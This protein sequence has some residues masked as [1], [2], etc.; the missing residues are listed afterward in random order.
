MPADLAALLKRQKFGRGTLRPFI[1][2]E[3]GELKGLAFLSSQDETSDIDEKNLSA[4]FLI[5][6]PS[7]DRALDVVPPKSLDFSN[8]EKNAT[9]LWNHG[10]NENVP[11]PLGTSIDPETKQLA[12]D[13]TERGVFAKCFFG[14]GVA[15]SEDMFKLV[16]QGIV[17]AASIHMVAPIEAKERTPAKK[18]GRP[19]YEIVKASIAEWSLVDIPC[20]QDACR[21]AADSGR[22]LNERLSDE[23]HEIL[24]GMVAGMPKPKMLGK[25]WTFDESEAKAAATND[26]KTIAAHAEIKVALDNAAEPAGAAILAGLHAQ[27]KGMLATLKAAAVENPTVNECLVELAKTLDPF[28]ATCEGGYASAY[29]DGIGLDSTEAPDAEAVTKGI[30]ETLEA[31][32]NRWLVKG[33]LHRLQNVAGADNLRDGQRVALAGV[34]ELVQKAVAL[35]EASIAK[36]GKPEAKAGDVNLEF[37]QEL[38]KELKGLRADRKKMADELA[39]LKPYRP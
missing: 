33:A 32:G 19:G 23:V 17:K 10:Q 16:H 13:I 38:L 6:T 5:S 37:Q 35:G 9:V 1:D 30:L 3:N 7:V 8:F 20:N 31:G 15:Q 34:V 26:E 18:G 2:E 12:L 25:G 14:K 28:I 27:A 4:R 21:K 36:G 11:F 22:L 24:K 39:D 29:P